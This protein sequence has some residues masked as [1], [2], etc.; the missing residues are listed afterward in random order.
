MG[1][2]GARVAEGSATIALPYGH[3]TGRHG[4]GGTIMI[5]DKGVVGRVGVGV[6]CVGVVGNGSVTTVGE[7]VSVVDGVL[8]VVVVVGVVYVSVSVG[9]VNGGGVGRQR[10]GLSPVFAPST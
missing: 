8:L 5:V 3:Q 4:L 7:R 1:S 10:H 2:P 9:G 6:V